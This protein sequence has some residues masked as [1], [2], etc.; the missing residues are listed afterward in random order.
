MLAPLLPRLLW[1]DELRWFITSFL[2]W[3]VILASAEQ[4]RHVEIPVHQL[5]RRK[6]DP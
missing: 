6:K 4:I 5:E 2:H 1:P 3:P